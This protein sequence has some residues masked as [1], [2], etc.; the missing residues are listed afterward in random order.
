MVMTGITV[1]DERNVVALNEG[2]LPSMSQLRE[3]RPKRPSYLYANMSWHFDTREQ[4]LAWTLSAIARRGID[5]IHR[6]EAAGR[7]D[8]DTWVL[9]VPSRPDAVFSGWFEGKGEDYC[10]VL[11]RQAIR[12]SGQALHC[13]I[14]Y[15]PGI[16]ARKQSTIPREMRDAVKARLN[17]LVHAYGQGFPSVIELLQEMGHPFVYSSGRSLHQEVDQRAQ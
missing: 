2:Y 5:H 16:P 14:G 13:C 6:G 1:W 4:A 17:T 3:A 10:V 11:Q 9:G 8:V 12:E 15:V 7:V